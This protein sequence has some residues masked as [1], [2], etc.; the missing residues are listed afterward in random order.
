[1][2]PIIGPKRLSK[3]LMD[4]GR[5]RNI[6]YVETFDAL[7]IARSVLRPST[8]LIH[9]ITAGHGARP[10]GRL[11]LLVMF[12]DPSN[13]YTKQLQFEVMDFS[14]A[15]NAILGRPCYVKFMVVPI[16]MYLK[17]KMPGPHGIIM[18]FASFHVSYAREQASCELASAQA[19]TRELVE[20]RKGTDLQAE[21]EAPKASS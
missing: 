12:G 13:F 10:L 9:G 8:T 7:G 3:V 17:L 21:M 14:G 19:A 6:M 1:M 11:I 16:Y 2:G 15:Y 4:G 5:D 18:A 20:L